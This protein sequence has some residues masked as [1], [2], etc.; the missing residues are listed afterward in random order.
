MMIIINKPIKD[1]SY[2]KF[3]SRES[4]TLLEEEKDPFGD[5][6]LP[7]TLTKDIHITEV[8]ISQSSKKE[9]LILQVRERCKD[10]VNVFHICDPIDINTV[11]TAYE[12]C[13]H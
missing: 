11:K 6:D 13:K 3:N 12:D 2:T 8:D 5:T 10:R 1:V 4:I 9:D 7:T